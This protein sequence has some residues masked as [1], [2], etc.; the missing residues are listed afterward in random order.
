MA[1]RDLSPATESEA[2]LIRD[3]SMPQIN[4]H[5]TVVNAVTI[6]S[7]GNWIASGGADCTVRVWETAHW[8]MQTLMRVENAIHTCTW[9]HGGSLAC[10]GPAGL[11]VF[12]FLT[13]DA[14]ATDP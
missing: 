14:P 2:P 10:A 9:L 13:W 1:I 6:S 4:W 3:S 8:Q 12:D 5:R 11:Y 7:D